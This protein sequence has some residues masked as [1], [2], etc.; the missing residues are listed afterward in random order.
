M[1][2]TWSRRGEHVHAG[3]GGAGF[4]TAHHGGDLGD[5]LRIGCDRAQRLEERERDQERHSIR[6]R[7]DGEH[8]EAPTEERHDRLD[9]AHTSQLAPIER[10]GGDGGMQERRGGHEQ[11][12]VLVG[13]D[14][15][16]L[17]AILVHGR[18]HLGQQQWGGGGRVAP[19]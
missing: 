17:L 4:P 6:R 14:G 16:R 10:R 19:C 13:E 1:V 11:L 7:R 3:K 15:R 5:A 12:G 2:S 9:A 18:D 8:R